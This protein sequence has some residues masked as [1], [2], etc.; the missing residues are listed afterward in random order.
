MVIETAEFRRIM[1]NDFGVLCTGIP[2]VGVSFT[3][4]AIFDSRHSMEDAGGSLM[5]SSNQPRLTCV[6]D[7]VVTLVEGDT[8]QVPVSGVTKDFVVVVSMPDGTGI[9]EFAMEEQ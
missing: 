8:I 7:D 2:L 5:F 9:T 4:T 1:V 6:S 3:F